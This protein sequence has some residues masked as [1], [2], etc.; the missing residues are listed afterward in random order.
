VALIG[1]MHDNTFR[2]AVLKHGNSAG[3][4]ATQSIPLL[5]N[6]LGLRFLSLL[7]IGQ[8]YQRK[9]SAT[10]DGSSLMKPLIAWNLDA[11]DGRGV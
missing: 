9:I 11:P 7:C 10:S 3:D 6:D 8:C 1:Q 5:L 4:E 2:L